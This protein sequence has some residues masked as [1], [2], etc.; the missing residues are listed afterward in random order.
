MKESELQNWSGL[1]KA[2]QLD[3]KDKVEKILSI[4]AR[5]ELWGCTVSPSSLST[6]MGPLG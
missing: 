2:V 6:V 3:S 4:W 1:G 5:W